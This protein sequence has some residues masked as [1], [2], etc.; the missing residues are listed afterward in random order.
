MNLDVLSKVS[1]ST[2]IPESYVKTVLLMIEEGSTIPFIARYRKEKT[3]NLDE[4]QL[5]NIVLS[6][7]FEH[8]LFTR[9][10]EVLKNIEDKGKLTEE[11]AKK[12]QLSETI[13]EV[14]DL[15][16][17]YK[18]KKKTRASTAIANG[19]EPLANEILLFAKTSIEDLAK[20]YINDIIAS[21]EQA[22]QGAQ[23]IIAERISDNAE[24]RKMIRESILAYGMIETSIKK[25]AK[26]EKKVYENYYNYHELLRNIVNHRILAINR[27]ENEDILKVKITNDEAYIIRTLQKAT[28]KSYL[29]PSKIV[30]EQAIEDSYKRLL[31]PSLEREI[32]TLLTSRAEEAAIELFSVNLEQLLLTPPLKNTTILG[33][34]P[35][36]RT[37]CK[38][39]VI[40]G[41]GD[42]IC[43]TVIYPHEKYIGES[44]SPRRIQEA[45]ET[46][47]HL[48]KEHSIQ[49]IAIGNGTASRESEEF[50]SQLIKE[51]NL[52]CKYIIVSEAGA[53]VYSASEQAKKEFP[54]LQV[55]E[56]SAIS[57]ARRVIDPLAELI[58]IDPKS[59]GV[60]QYQHDV[61]Q[62]KLNSSLDFTISKVVN[63]VGVNINSASTALLSYVSGLSKKNAENIVNYRIDNGTISSR[64][65]VKKV[66]GIGPKSYEQAIGFLKILDSKN[67][68]DKTFIHPDNYEIVTKLLTTL[69]LDKTMIGSQK[70]IDCL[71]HVQ[72]EQ[73]AA[74]LGIGIFT[75]EDIIKEL[76]KPLRDIRDEY[77]SPILRSD[78]LHME[79][80]T[81]GMKLQG[82]IRSIVDF[83]VFV[84]IGLKN[85]GLIHKSKLS[86]TKISHPLDVVS[87]GDI[88][89]VYVCDIS[90]EKNRVGLS[91][92]Q[93]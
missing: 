73:L 18:E 82:T 28:I 75:M 43:K 38:L 8:K 44:A 9:K 79:D 86:K 58:K 49:L 52:P 83:G 74:N 47:L 14:E 29:S 16:L 81:I 48:I 45:K 34:D 87:I 55:E 93:E 20:K 12:I 59:I 70:F 40:N 31:F 51:Y 6:Y 84:D 54:D 15:Y 17:P 68:L 19:L 65:E 64:N 7:E 4:D 67:P 33:L 88:V 66:K 60:G 72:I 91:L 24:Y 57:I 71:E 22:I 23:D 36:F 80:L 26:D 90:K 77:P 46:V 89:T 13:S 50:I 10:E 2:N 30:I 69:Q 41:N 37:G 5:R 63:S 32:R 56:R 1:L 21:T 42:F 35:A 61:N 92:F 3:N 53:S 62:T 39:S 25:D 11:L 27:G 85:D 76:T 78:I